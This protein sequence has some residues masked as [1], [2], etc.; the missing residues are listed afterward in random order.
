[1]ADVNGDRFADILQGDAVPERAPAD[2]SAVGGE[3]RL[4]QGSAD[5]PESD[6]IVISQRGGR[7]PGD[8]APG[9][10]FGATVDSGDL[11]SDGFADIV[12]AAP[13]DESGAG[14]VTVIRGVRT[15]YARGGNTRFARGDGLPGKP[16]SGDQVGKAVA[17]MDVSGDDH[18]DVAVAVRRATDLQDAVLL[19]EGG[20][21]A[22]AQGERAVRLPLA[23]GPAVGDPRIGWI[24]IARAENR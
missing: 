18:L 6:P 13:G 11:D 5:G 8:D 23:A 21:G 15:G 2:R 7:V 16:A 10:L 22:F 24:R 14:S 19:I 3:V 17:V 1:V 9:D 4:W 20:P 12:V